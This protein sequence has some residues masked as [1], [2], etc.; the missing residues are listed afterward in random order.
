MV[1]I[2]D[3]FCEWFVK[4]YIMLMCLMLASIPF[5]AIGIVLYWW[6]K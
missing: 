6:L 2:V 5:A 1:K 3:V 4:I